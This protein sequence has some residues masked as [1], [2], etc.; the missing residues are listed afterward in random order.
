MANKKYYIMIKTQKVYIEQITYF[1]L[2]MQ[3]II[4]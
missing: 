3:E 4:F 2:R 1:N